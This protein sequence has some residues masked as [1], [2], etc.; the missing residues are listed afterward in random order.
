MWYTLIHDHDLSLSKQLGFSMLGNW[1]GDVISGVAM[2]P[3]ALSAGRAAASLTEEES[4]KPT[5]TSNISQ[6]VSS[7]L[8]LVVTSGIGNGWL[9][10]LSI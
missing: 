4:R 9:V 10:L 8:L 1:P 3:L 7:R 2:T 6:R 5:E